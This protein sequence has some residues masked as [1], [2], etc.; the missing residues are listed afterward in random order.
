[1]TTEPYN[2][3]MNP[4]YF[5]YQPVS[6]RLHGR[7]GSRQAL[8]D[9]IATCRSH[10]VRVYADAVV[11]HMVGNGNDVSKFHRNPGAGCTY[12]GNKTSSADFNGAPGPA[13]YYTMGYAYAPSNETMLAP[14][15][16]FPAVPYG[17]LDF[18]C[19]RVLNAWND[20]LQLNAGW[21]VGL[22][23]L[24]T[25][26]EN[27]QQ[28]IADYWTDLL[29]IG[30]SAFRIDAAKH[31]K[32]DDLAAIFAKF[33]ANLGGSLPADWFTWLEV[34]LGG[35]KDLLICND[36][37]GY[38]Y[39]AYLA[40][41]LASVG[42]TSTE[43]DQVKLWFSGYPAETD[44]DCGKVSRK[45]EVIQNDDHDQQNPGSSSRDM[46]DSGSVLV[47]DKDVA[48]H[49][50]FEVKLFEAPFGATDNDNDW[51]HRAILSSYWFLDDGTMAPPD[52]L[53]DCALCTTNCNGCK[54]RQHVTAFKPDSVGYD[55]AG[56]YTRVHR[57]GAIIN[58]MRAWMHLP[59]M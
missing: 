45:R 8:R 7:G 49:R 25:E 38:N 48:K 37:S 12:W 26:R 59:P 4:W 23:D 55:V 11:N 39:G 31:I 54:G 43:I 51:P 6:Y 40:A 22:V 17:P 58:A 21:L 20:P 10:N 13:P 52:G 47:K 28:R 57:D 33:K 35:E 16:E 42:F 56:E 41:A 14:M 46:H 36:D 3:E 30:F 50:A 1:M 29:G 2:N 44:A 15:Q 9:M 18:H 34:L 19:S 27:V 24:N 5:M 53:S 32:P